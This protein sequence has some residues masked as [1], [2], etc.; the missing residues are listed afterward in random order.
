MKSVAGV[1]VTGTDTGVGKTHVACR[2]VRSLREAG[3][4][5]GV[6]KPV[7]AGG[8]ADA[9]RLRS[10]AGVRDPLSRINPVWYSKPAAP[11]AILGGRR[12]PIARVLAAW[13]R[14]ARGHQF[15]VVEGIGG[16]Q[17]PL[18][19]RLT[20][21]DL[22]RALAL[23]ALVVARAGLGTLNHTLL[24][25]EA[26]RRARVPVFGIVLNGKAGGYAGKTN[27]ALLRRLTGLP[28]WRIRNQ[29]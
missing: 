3:L 2:L 26:L 22:V 14:L 8:R 16:A 25:V 5:V 7:A 17:V 23:P 29:R 13:R 9:R 4:D 28:V 1:F 27:P 12:F 10:A 20:G 21:L 6:M 19:G 15:M 24:T 18:D 11:A